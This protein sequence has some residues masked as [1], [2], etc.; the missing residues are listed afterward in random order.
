[1]CIMGGHSVAVLQGF[2]MG[3]LYLE[4]LY[5]VVEVSICRASPMVGMRRGLIKSSR[6]Y[7]NISL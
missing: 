5:T 7:R 2:L 4:G 1:M 6:R 3:R